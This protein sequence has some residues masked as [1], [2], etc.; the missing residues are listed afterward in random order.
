MS[1][2]AQ[3]LLS[4]KLFTARADLGSSWVAQRSG[5]CFVSS[6]STPQRY[7][8]CKMSIFNGRT[9]QSF[10]A[11]PIFLCGF[12]TSVTCIV[13]CLHLHELFSILESRHSDALFLP[14]THRRTMR[15]LRSYL[16]SA[17]RAGLRSS[18]VAQLRRPGVIPIVHFAMRVPDIC[19]TRCLGR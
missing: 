14:G 15:H 11:I 9:P 16:S 3:L 4:C 5:A 6:L 7:V 1:Q 8:A 12:D 2:S 19:F 13:H 17:G 18:Q 10:Q